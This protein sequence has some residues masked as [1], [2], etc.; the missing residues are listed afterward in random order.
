VTA[1]FSEVGVS[2]A[3]AQTLAREA[4]VTKIVD[5]LPT[6]SVVAPPAD[7]YIGVIRTVTQKIVD[8]LK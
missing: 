5:D 2:P 4:G 3:L 7:T 6:D 1:I 8:A